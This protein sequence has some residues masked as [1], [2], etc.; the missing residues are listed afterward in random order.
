MQLY[1][2]HPHYKSKYLT[3]RYS[4]L[5]KSPGNLEI[6]LFYNLP[7]QYPKN[8]LHD[9]SVRLQRGNTYVNAND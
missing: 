5:N 1:I 8:D 4:R 7:A 3:E 2:T 9:G 6:Y